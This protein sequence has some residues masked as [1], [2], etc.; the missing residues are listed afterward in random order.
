MRAGRAALPGAPIIAAMQPRPTRANAG[1][2]ELR[3]AP[4]FGRRRARTW[5][6][7]LT[8]ALACC[9]TGCSSR[10]AERARLR[11]GNPI[12]RAVA[13][14]RL[15]AWRDEQAAPGLIGLLED[16]DHGVRMIAINSLRRLFGTDL[17]YRYYAEERERAQ[18]VDRWR[19]A[20]RRGDLSAAQRREVG[21]TTSPVAASQ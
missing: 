21:P 7:V 4:R 17:G 18:A 12:E 2:R 19:E 16:D 10:A 15:G 5:A 11:S 13:A 14:K 3:P 8:V 1:S 6:V 20:L 9:A